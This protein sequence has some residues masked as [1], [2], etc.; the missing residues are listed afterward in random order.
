MLVCVKSIVSC[1][2]VSL[3]FFLGLRK[4]SKKYCCFPQ[5]VILSNPA[6]ASM[7]E[8]N[9]NVK[10]SVAHHAARSIDVNTLQWE[11]DELNAHRAMIMQQTPTPTRTGGRRIRGRVQRRNT[12]F[13]SGFGGF[14]RFWPIRGFGRV[15]PPP[16][17]GGYVFPIHYF[18][19]QPLIRFKP[20][21]HP[22]P[23]YA[24]GRR[25]FGPYY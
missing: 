12:D 24:Y 23:F 6:H 8:R 10:E 20:Y 13:R 5:P 25:H 16:F 9:D 14:G 17:G 2:N 1:A 22:Y 11:I 7:Q 4:F 21:L 3:Y 18:S 19:Y 15:Y